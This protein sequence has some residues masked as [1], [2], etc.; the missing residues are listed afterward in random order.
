MDAMNGEP[1]EHH[2]RHQRPFDRKVTAD[3]TGLVGDAGTVLLRKA[4]D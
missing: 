1:G 3:G 4:A 2:E